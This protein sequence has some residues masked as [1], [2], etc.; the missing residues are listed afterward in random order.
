MV[1]RPAGSSSLDDVHILASNNFIDN[2]V[3][4]IIGKPE[5]NNPKK[6]FK[7]YWHENSLV[8]TTSFILY[9]LCQYDIS[10]L[11]YTYFVSTTSPSLTPAFFA[12]S[13]DSSGWLVPPKTRRFQRVP[14]FVPYVRLFILRN[15][16]LH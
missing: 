4:L 10:N 3:C 9:L 8:K 5:G 1:M 7:Y 14:S 13:R 16:S 6:I 11:I 12:T 15:F 2:N